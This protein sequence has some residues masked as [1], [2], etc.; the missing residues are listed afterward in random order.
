MVYL[1]KIYDKD[2]NDKIMLHF[3]YVNHLNEIF[4]IKK[5]IEFIIDGKISRERLLYILRENQ[6]LNSHKHKLIS[7]S[8]INFDI[9]E[10]EIELL[11][12]NKLEKDYWKLLDIVDDIQFNTSLEL[13]TKQNCI[14]F[15]LKELTK[16]ERT[17][18][19]ILLNLN[20]RKTRKI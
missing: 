18:K 8:Y 12:N 14:F 19:K 10:T 11:A 5:K 17:T 4:C 1:T 9:K 2:S 3:F 13:F 16:S 6:L 7:L 20:Y 15:I